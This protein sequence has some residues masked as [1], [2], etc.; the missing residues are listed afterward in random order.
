MR[1]SQPFYDF[2]N[3]FAFTFHVYENQIKCY[4]NNL[5][6]QIQ[7][8]LYSVINTFKNMYLDLRNLSIILKYDTAQAE[9][10]R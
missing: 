8:N 2:H 4:E 9:S 1:I 3:F 5:N 6:K 7:W 10:K